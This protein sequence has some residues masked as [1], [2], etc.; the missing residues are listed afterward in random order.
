[1][2][3]RDDLSALLAAHTPNIVT[4]TETFLDDEI[5]DSEIVTN[6]YTVFRHDR[7]RHGGG[8][9]ALVRNNISATQRNDLESNSELAWIEISHTTGKLLL[10]IFYRPPNSDLSYLKTLQDSLL[11]IPD[12]TDIILCGDFNVPDVNWEINTP[13]S[14]SP[15][16]SL[17]CDITSSAALRQFVDEPTRGNNI[18]DL[19]FTNMQDRVTNVQVVDGLPGSDH[20][21]VHFNI[22]LKCQRLHKPPR[23]LYNFKKADFNNFRDI[24]STIPWDSCFL[25]DSVEQSWIK[26]KD[27][28][29]T[30]ADQCIPTFTLKHNKTKGYISDEVLSLIK[31]KRRSYR[32]AKRSGNQ[33]YQ[34][35]Y[36]SLCNTVRRL[37]RRDKDT[38]LED[39]TSNLS[40][41]QK[42]F[43]QW[44]K[45][46]RSG[47]CTIP[48]IHFANRI[49]KTAGDKA[50]AL[51]NFF[52]SVFTI[53]TTG[54]NPAL[55]P[56]SLIEI[57]C[58]RFKPDNVCNLLRKIDPSKSPGPDGIP[59]L[60]LKEGAPQIAEPLSKLFNPSL[61]TGQLPSDWTRANITPIHKK[62]SKHLPNNYR[63]ISLT[64]TVVKI[65]EHLIHQELS[66]FLSNNNK[67][68]TSQHGFRSKHSCQTQLLET[69][70]HWANALDQRSSVHVIFLDFSKTFDTVPHL[71]LC[72]K[73]DNIGVRGNILSWIK[74]FLT[75]R[76]QRVCVDGRSSDWSSISSGVPQGSILGPLLFLIYINDITLSLNSKA[77]LFADDCTLY[78][79]VSSAE[80][81]V[82]LQSD[83]AK[84]YSWTQMWQL[85]LNTSK[86]K[87]LNISNKRTPPTYRYNIN[88]T[89]LEF[90]EK[91]KYLGIYINRHLRWNDN[92][93]YASHKATRILNLLRRSMY[94]CSKSAKERAVSA[95]VRPHLEYVAPVWEPHTITGKAALEKVQ[96]RAAHWICSRWDRQ[97]HK[98]NKTYDEARKELHWPTISQRHT[99]LSSC[100]TYKIL[101][102]LDCIQ[103]NQYFRSNPRN[104]RPHQLICNHSRIDCYRYSYFTNAPFVWNNLPSH[105]VISSSLPLFRTK[106][107][108][109]F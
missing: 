23:R 94:R 60:L 87:V 16:A 70:H 98:W 75:N 12:N 1:M 93:S 74:A 67:L 32:M 10:G 40:H 15:L 34:S 92:V 47:L 28:L 14:S 76:Q 85:S 58:I 73:L 30:A 45:S 19:V 49:L 22:T 72:A 95:L 63:P 105:I 4:L 62:G 56:R 48:D 50:K 57:S 27:I 24:L 21:G 86:C 90:V 36:R 26:F 84:V 97:T 11:S 101:H 68:I 9:M 33:K 66:Q 109:H 43:W 25:E 108:S 42:P 44:L 54:A 91:M 106:L 55:P 39:L 81:C 102:S 46:I 82:L 29:M 41:N 78:R 6:S 79:T 53:E 20:D 71:K 7:N 64:C 61:A 69:V 59:G 88:N 65:M 80:D 18:L 52:T 38:Y 107:T 8:V 13:T 31:K 5:Y 89:P 104:S 100:Q 35:R 77:R 37:T 83:L 103:F 96:K 99:I 3:K 2:N 51:N 17:L